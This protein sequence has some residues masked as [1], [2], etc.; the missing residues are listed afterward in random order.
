MIQLEIAIILCA[1]HCNIFQVLLTLFSVIDF[2]YLCVKQNRKMFMV[3]FY[4]GAILICRMDGLM[5]NA[6]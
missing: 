6:R 3:R 2:Y 4:L 1:E 5:F